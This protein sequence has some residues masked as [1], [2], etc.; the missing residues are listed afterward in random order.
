MFMRHNAVTTK[1]HRTMVHL[2]ELRDKDTCKGEW[3]AMLSGATF[4]SS[5]ISPDIRILSQQY[6]ALFP[7]IRQWYDAKG[8]FMRLA[9]R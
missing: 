3:M 2:P 8:Q 4:T 5:A 6:R 7:F 9:A 1:K